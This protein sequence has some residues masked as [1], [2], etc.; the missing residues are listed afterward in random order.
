LHVTHLG[1]GPTLAQQIALLFQQPLCTVEGCYRT[2][3]EFDHREDWVRTRHT[4]VDE[5][6]PLCTH[7]HDQKT[8]GGW[9]LIEGTGKRPMV[10]PDDTRHPRHRR[11]P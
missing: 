10:C 2:R 11:P 3:V 5:C 1:R 7:H 4:R 8:Y 6:D 9:A